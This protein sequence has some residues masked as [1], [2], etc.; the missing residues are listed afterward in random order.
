M[1]HNYNVSQRKKIV[2][3]VASSGVAALLLPGGRTTHSRFKIPCHDL[4]ETTT[5]NIKQETMLCELIH[6][7]SL[8]IWDEALMTNKIAFEALDKTLCDILSSH[9]SENSNLPFGGKVVVLGGDTRQ[10]LPVIEGGSRSQIVNSAIV[11]SS[12]WPH[13]T[14]LHLKR[15][16]R[17]L[18]PTLTNESRMELVR[19]SRWMLDV[20]EGN[21]ESRTKEGESEPSWIEIPDEFLLNATSDKVSCIT[22]IVYPELTSKYMDLEYL[23]ERAILTPTNDVADMINNEIASLIPEQE[24]QYLRCDTVVKAPN[25][26]DSY[27]LLY[28]VEFL[29]SLNGNNFPP[30]KLC[31][32][33]GVL[34]M[35][36]CNLNQSEGLCNGTR[37]IITILADMVIEGQIMSGTYKDKSVLIPRI[38]LTLKNYKLPFVL[39]RQQYPIKV[40][41]AMTINKSQGQTLSNVDIYL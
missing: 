23:K 19:F 9:S 12:L 34:V 26:H 37:L 3:C 8:I 36:L 20:G 40:C 18:V 41:Y 14:I 29:N 24:K 27:D 25:T 21:I 7:S 28:P 5:C 22:N 13:V 4:D 35:L 31:L 15:N 17:L 38:A 11:N 1:E 32:K 30:H 33:R 39:Q 2:L 16:M 6:S 10:T